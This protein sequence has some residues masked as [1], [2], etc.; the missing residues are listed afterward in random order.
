MKRFFLLVLGVAVAGCSNGLT[1][2]GYQARPISLLTAEDCTS[3][4]SVSDTKRTASSAV[5]DKSVETA[6]ARN[7]AAAIGGNA[8]ALSITSTAS[9]ASSFQMNAYRCPSNFPGL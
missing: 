5:R 3:I 9:G 8:V 7:R 4:G 6:N 2:S 1:L